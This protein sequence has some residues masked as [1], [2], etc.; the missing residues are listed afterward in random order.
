MAT[1]TKKPLKNPKKMLTANGKKRLDLKGYLA[2]KKASIDRMLDQ[3]LPSENVFPSRLHQAMR[4]C[5]FAGGKKIRPILALGA[6][7]AVG[8]SSD[9]FIQEVCA[10]ELI[11]TYTLIHDDLPSMDNGDYRRGSPTTHKIYGEAIA[12]LAGDALLTEAFH[13]LSLAAKENPNKTSQIVEIIQLI[14]DASGSR[15]LIGGQTVDLESEGKAIESCI[16]EYIHK[17]KTGRLITVSVLLGGILAGVSQ[18]EIACLTRYGE[19]IGQAFQI[20]DDILDS[21][22]T[23]S[24]LGKDIKSDSKKKK[25]TYPLLLGMEEAKRQQK[26]L[27]QDAINALISF[28]KKAAPLRAIGRYIIERKV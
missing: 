18:D 20:T 27:Y 7:E 10:L 17:Q 19:A 23:V 16:L 12:I 9:E 15:G 1:Y 5:L 4:Y 13:I 6:V 11:H 25:A 22:G 21:L 3:L 8:K 24:E 2:K 28:D 26:V 14:A